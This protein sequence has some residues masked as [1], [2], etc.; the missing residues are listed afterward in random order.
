MRA[1]CC[2]EARVIGLRNLRASLAPRKT[3]ECSFEALTV[4]SVASYSKVPF[5]SSC[6]PKVPSLRNDSLVPRL[7]LLVFWAT[8]RVAAV[9]QLLGS[10]SLIKASNGIIGYEECITYQK[11]RNTSNY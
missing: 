4:C 2:Y 9:L 1:V 10:L 3:S 8:G 5:A 11:S 6:S 7:L